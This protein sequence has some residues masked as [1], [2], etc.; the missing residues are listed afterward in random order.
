MFHGSARVADVVVAADPRAQLLPL[1]S[2]TDPTAAGLGDALAFEVRAEALDGDIFTAPIETVRLPTT[3]S[4]SDGNVRLADAQVVLIDAAGAE[5]RAEA[6]ASPIYGEL[7]GEFDAYP[8]SREYGLQNSY[9]LLRSFY[10]HTDAF[11]HGRWD[12]A[13]PTLGLDSA[14]PAGQF[15]PRLVVAADPAA[16]LCGAEAAGACRRPGPGRPPSRRRRCSTRP[17]PDRTRSSGRCTSR[18]RT[19][20]RRCCR[21]SSA[22]SS[23]CS[24][25]RA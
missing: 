24:P 17:A 9:Y 3:G 12:S 4:L 16:P 8:D 14:L 25:R 10:A 6:L 7:G 21:T 22:T 23:I 20:R 13:L 19:S 15:A 2:F 11:M 1:L 5:S 18:A